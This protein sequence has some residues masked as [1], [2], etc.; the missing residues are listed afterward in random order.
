MEY[1]TFG[2]LDWQVSALGFGCAR[3]PLQGE[4]HR[5]VDETEAVRMIRYAIDQGVNYFDTGYNY[6][7]GDSERVLGIALQDGYRERVK[8]VDKLPWWLADTVADFDRML[9][10]QLGRLQVD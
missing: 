4:E 2:K 8:L 7:D 5:D 1:R 6:H 9:D 3:L 10:E